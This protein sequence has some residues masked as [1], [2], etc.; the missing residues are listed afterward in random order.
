MTIQDWGAIGEMIGGIAVVVS[1][2]YLA[3]QIRQNTQQMVR[4]AEASRLAAFERNIESAN[5]IRELLIVHPEIASLMLRGLESYDDL[6]STE[7]FRFGMLMR[8]TLT[9]YQGAYLRHVALG[10]DS[11][12]FEGAGQQMDSILCTPGARA[13]LEQNKTDWRPEFREYVESRLAIAGQRASP[14]NK[15]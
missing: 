10:G 12:D 1:L 3:V 4:S 13:W 9:A 6:E 11:I 15:V 5:A 8:N 14:A 7:R 2:V